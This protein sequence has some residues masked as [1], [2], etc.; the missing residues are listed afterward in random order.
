MCEAIFCMASITCFSEA[1]VVVLNLKRF[2]GGAAFIRSFSISLLYQLASK[3]KST[4]AKDR[5]F[6]W[7]SVEK[8]TKRKKRLSSRTEH[9]FKILILVICIK[10]STETSKRKR[11]KTSF[12]HFCYYND[13]KLSKL[14]STFKLCQVLK[15][16]AIK[17]NTFTRNP[18]YRKTVGFSK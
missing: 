7:I 4:I 6:T 11:H 15:R 5:I 17:Y 13:L 18:H 3:C 1:S 9:K 16:L 2:S 10:L 12:T 8:L 14:T